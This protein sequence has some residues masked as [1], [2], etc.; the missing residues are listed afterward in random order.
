MQ[1]IL[2]VGAS[3]GIGLALVENYLQQGHQV[4]ATLRKAGNSAL[5]ALSRKHPGKLTQILC[6]LTDTDA[7]ATI[8]AAL[9]DITLDV[10]LFNAG[11]KGPDSLD[12]ASKEEVAS[13][14]ITNTL[15]PVRMARRLSHRVSPQ[16]VIAFTSSQ[17][18]SVSLALSASMPLY[19][20]SKAA[21][22]SLLQSWNQAEDKP[23][24]TL[25]ALHPGWV[26][27][28]MGGENAAVN[29]TES[30]TGLIET[31]QGFYGVGGCHFADY[32][33]RPMPW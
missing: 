12:D 15:A 22:N 32:R 16:G 7:V 19:G 25:L 14:F 31:I 5:D 27:T 17:M 13:L 4:F 26:K 30:A 11:I 28:D 6:D 9:G 21:L 33:Q 2:V 8:E 1:Y 10:A 3:R 29:V 18:G 20:A 24:S 23:A